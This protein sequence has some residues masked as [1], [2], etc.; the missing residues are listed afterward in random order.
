MLMTGFGLPQENV[1]MRRYFMTTIA[2]L[3]RHA[4]DL[5]AELGSELLE[6]Y[7]RLKSPQHVWVVE[8]C[9]IEQWHR[10]VV[11]GRVIVDATA[12]QLDRVP[13]LLIHDVVSA[14]TYDRSL[15]AEHHSSSLLDCAA[16]LS[17][18][19]LELNLME[20]VRQDN[21]ETE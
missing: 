11:A 3:R 1:Q 8:F 20:L 7:L 10:R 17:L 21:V 15:N 16:D 4:R 6:L 14:V 12:S 18:P 9:S 13:M 5:S 2:E 19:R